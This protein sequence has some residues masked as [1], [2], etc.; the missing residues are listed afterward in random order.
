MVSVTTGLDSMTVLMKYLAEFADGSSSQIVEA[1]PRLLA[2]TDRQSQSHQAW[3]DQGPQ[4]PVYELG[5]VDA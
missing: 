4:Y 1:Y 5:S 2:T 3:S